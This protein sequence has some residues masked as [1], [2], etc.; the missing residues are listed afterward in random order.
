MDK[1]L[2]IRGARIG[3][4]IWDVGGMFAFSV[5]FWRNGLIKALTSI[6]IIKL[7]IVSCK[8]FPHIIIN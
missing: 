4:R 1:T 5:K 8:V 3:F 6:L 7:I 2:H